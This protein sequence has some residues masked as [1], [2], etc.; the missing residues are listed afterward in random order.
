MNILSVNVG[1]PR[2]VHLQGGVVLT[3]IFKTPVE[4]RLAVRKH[5]IEGDRQT[6]LRVHGGPNKAVYAYPSEHY[7]YWKT[8]LPDAQLAWGAF[9]ENLTLSGL[10]EIDAQIGDK[11]Q[12][13]SSVLE[14]T[15]PRMPC[16]KLNLRFQRSDMVKRFWRSGHSGIYFAIREEG[17]LAAGDELHLVH[18]QTD[19]ISIA[20]VVRLYKRE[21][22]DEELYD[23]ALRAPLRGSW[24]EEIRERWQQA[25]LFQ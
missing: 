22:H 18:R 12:V 19:S 16:F 21:T 2:E 7:P 11:Y 5:N 1:Q 6:D 13:G 8:E 17:E 15:Q 25:P 23:R 24:K 20:D 9:G 10:T 14:V 3:S 4:G